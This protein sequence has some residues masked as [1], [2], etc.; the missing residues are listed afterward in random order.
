M[1]IVLYCFIMKQNKSGNSFKLN[2][3]TLIYIYHSHLCE[4]NLISSSLVLLYNVIWKITLVL[5]WSLC[6]YT[7]VQ[8]FGVIIISIII[9]LIC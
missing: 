1:A 5:T 3:D 2:S 7:T 8:K 9:F 6:E 4:T